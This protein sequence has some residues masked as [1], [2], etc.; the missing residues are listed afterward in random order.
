MLLVELCLRFRWNFVSSL[1]ECVWLQIEYA[2][3]LNA[4]ASGLTYRQRERVRENETKHK[5][6]KRN[7]RNK[8]W[9]MAWHYPILSFVSLHIQLQSEWSLWEMFFFPVLGFVV[10]QCLYMWLWNWD[11]CEY[12]LDGVAICGGVCFCVCIFALN[13]CFYGF[14]AYIYLWIIN[15]HRLTHSTAQHR[16]YS[17]V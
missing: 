11:I 2:I 12:G 5:Q 15:I 7:Q 9:I 4:K 16:T 14:P 3:R 8:T 13:N 6:T 1:F 17:I 10:C